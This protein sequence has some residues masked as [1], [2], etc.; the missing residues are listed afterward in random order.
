LQRARTEV[1]SY[2]N[3]KEKGKKKMS[4]KIETLKAAR[5]QDV[6]DVLQL[7]FSFRTTLRAGSC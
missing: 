1:G 6:D 2:T 5:A 3:T 4:E 7:D